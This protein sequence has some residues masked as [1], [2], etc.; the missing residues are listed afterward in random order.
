M[1]SQFFIILLMLDALIVAVGLAKKQN[2]WPFIITYWC[3]LTA[4][5]VCDLVDTI[6]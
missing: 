1:M 4:K 5:N 2:M 3:I 6:R